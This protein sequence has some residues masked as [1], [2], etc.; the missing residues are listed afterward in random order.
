MELAAIDLY[1]TVNEACYKNQV[2]KL[3][4]LK[5]PNETTSDVHIK[6]A[7]NYAVV[8]G[9]LDVIKYIVSKVNIDLC[10]ET[11]I[12]AIKYNHLEIVK[13]LYPS[14]GFHKQD[15]MDTIAVSHASLP[16]IK[17]IFSKIDDINKHIWLLD[18]A[19]ERND[20]KIVEYIMQ[21]VKIDERTIKKV[22]LNN[23]YDLNIAQYLSQYITITHNFLENICLHNPFIIFKHFTKCIETVI[24]WDTLLDLATDDNDYDIDTIKYIINKGAKLYSA[25][26]ANQ[27]ERI[28]EALKSMEKDKQILTILNQYL[29]NDVSGLI[30]EYL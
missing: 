18:N 25:T 12:N 9:H 29:S 6:T 7:L 14:I 8:P 15:N 22:L 27:I 3:I 28:Q 21:T 17:V 19:V 10:K 5:W 11:L 26:Q 16:V 2:N 4:E 1:Y 13:Y 20:L 30:L 24:D 23:Q